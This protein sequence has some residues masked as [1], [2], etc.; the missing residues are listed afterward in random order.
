MDQVYD[1][2]AEFERITAERYPEVFNSNHDRTEFDNRSDDK[3]PEPEG[4][5][6]AKLWGRTYAF[7][8][9][10]RIGGVMVY[11]IS[12]PYAPQFVQY[13]N[14]RDFDA[15]DLTVPR[16]AISVA[17]GLI[18]IEADEEPDPG[19]TAAGGGQ[20]GQRHH[21]PVP[22]RARAQ[23]NSHISGTVAWR[24]PDG[25]WI[26]FDRSLRSVSELLMRNSLA[27]PPAGATRVAQ[28]SAEP[29]TWGDRAGYCNR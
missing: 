20:R 17:E 1:S 2:G 28:A 18:V 22:Y 10:E 11:D 21:H 29:Q 8:G 19:C 6:I 25:V 14:N 16:R 15:A 7:I 27:L 24:W 5:A 13:L 9:L 12:N 23:G 4:V 3:G 26:D